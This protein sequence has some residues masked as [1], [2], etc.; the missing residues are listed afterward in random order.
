MKGASF[1]V[2]LFFILE[3]DVRVDLDAAEKPGGLRLD[4]GFA[5]SKARKRR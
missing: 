4:V 5:A 2:R 1:G 3:D